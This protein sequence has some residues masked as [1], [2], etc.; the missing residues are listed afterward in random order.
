[1]ISLTESAVSKVSSM[2]NE[3]ENGKVLRVFIEPGGCSGFEYGMSV[4]FPKE[5]D[6]VGESGGVAYAVDGDSLEYLQGCEVHFDDG[7][8]GKGFEI[9]NPNAQSTCG[10]GKSFH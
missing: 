10:C 5:S 4:D 8:T 1:M 7:L 6:K 3:N 9:R 2:L